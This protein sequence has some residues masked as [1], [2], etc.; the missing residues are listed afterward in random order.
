MGN[1]ICRNIKPVPEEIEH[2]LYAPASVENLESMTQYLKIQ[3]GL[4][5]EN[6]EHVIFLFGLV[7]ALSAK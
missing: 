2:L 7:H 6:E 1:F 5:F 4:L 3:P